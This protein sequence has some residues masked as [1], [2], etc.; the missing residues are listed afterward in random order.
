MYPNL[1]HVY[2]KLNFYIQNQGKNVQE[3]NF[4]EFLSIAHVLKKN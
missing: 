3:F 2:V 1:Y 4:K